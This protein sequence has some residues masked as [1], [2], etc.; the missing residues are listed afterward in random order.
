[1]ERHYVFDDVH[2]LLK[3]EVGKRFEQVLEHAGVFKRT[4]EGKRAFHRFIQH[5]QE[6][7]E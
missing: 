1:M 4:E 2:E 6:R 7:N 3:E 5:L